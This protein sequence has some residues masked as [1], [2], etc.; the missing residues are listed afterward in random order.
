[1]S[2]GSLLYKRGVG[3]LAYIS[4]W[5]YCEPRR[6]DYMSKVTSPRLP[7]FSKIIF[8]QTIEFVL[9]NMKKRNED[10]QNIREDN[11]EELSAESLVF[12]NRL[13]ERLHQDDYKPIGG[14]MTI[15]IVEP[16]AQ[17]VE[18]IQSQNIYNYKRQN[19]SEEPTS[20]VPPS[21]AMARAVERTM[22]QG[23]WWAST[24][25]AVVY[26][27]YQ[28]EGFTG[29]IRQFVREV[30]EWPWQKAL[31]FP[32]TYD[33]IQK[34]IVSGKLSGS[35]DKWKEDG[36]PEQMQRLAQRLLDLLN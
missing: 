19:A 23:Y 28:M 30:K 21:E 17:H 1:M 10:N 16:G 33:S 12:I 22:A 29:S 11:S 14:N 26:R 34:P 4:A 36:A 13:L 18:T 8:S 6:A 7:F 3:F 35:I 24:A 5:V 9:R 27:I 20:A 15:V 31:A 32:C 2:A 25:W